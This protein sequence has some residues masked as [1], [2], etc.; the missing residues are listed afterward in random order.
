MIFWE[1]FFIFLIGLILGSFLN[2]VIYRL[3]Q[4]KSLIFPASHCPKCETPL[5]WYH[6]IPLLSFLFL[7]GRCAYCKAS[8][9]WQYPLVEFLSGLLLVLLY[10]K[11]KPHY[12]VIVFSFFAFFGLN[13]LCL[14]FIDLF[15]KEIPDSLSFSLIFSGWILALLSKNPLSLSF[16]ESLLS[17]FAGIGLLF[18][19]NELYYLL[20]K[21]DG[22]GMGD[23]KL[24]GGLGAYLGYKSFF[25]VLFFASLIGVV[26]FILMRIYQKLSREDLETSEDLLK[27]EIPFGPFL[28]IAGLIYLFYPQSL[29]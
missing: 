20:A 17:S 22:L 26:C 19:I 29:L 16:L 5:R 25:N 28:S 9:S 10:L 21:R 15:H 3:P 24:M 23:F 18:F 12:G 6:N 4:G 2:V 1:S 27:K 8:I 11:F 14:S 7:K 13:L